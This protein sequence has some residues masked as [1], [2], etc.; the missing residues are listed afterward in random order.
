MAIRQ[1]AVDT[2]T[3]EI[4]ATQHLGEQAHLAAGAATL[5]LNTPGRQRCLATHG[6]DKLIAQPVDFIGDG[7]E[8]PRAFFRTQVTVGRVCRS[9]RLGSGIHFGFAGL[10][11]RYG[12]GFAG[13]GVEALQLQRAVG[14]AATAD[15]VVSRK[16]AHV[17]SLIG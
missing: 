17:D 13:G 8:K 1:C 7:V 11:E 3:V 15:V 9:R 6:G 14:A 10:E 12:Q 5:T 2:R 16:Q 4:A